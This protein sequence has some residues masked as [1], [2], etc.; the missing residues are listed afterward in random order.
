MTSYANCTDA[1]CL[2]KDYRTKEIFVIAGKG[3]FAELD[4]KKDVES[5][6]WVDLT[7][8]K[9]ESK[10]VE[11]LAQLR[12]CVPTFETRAEAAKGL[13]LGDVV[14]DLEKLLAAGKVSDDDLKMLL[15]DRAFDTLSLACKSRGEIARLRTFL[16]NQKTEVVS[17]QL[18]DV[19]GAAA[20]ISQ[21]GND[22]LTAKGNIVPGLG[23]AGDLA[24]GVKVQM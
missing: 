20:I 22:E 6:E 16:S 17:I 14:V 13:D 12:V 5:P 4:Q 3:C 1:L 7:S 11:R 21:L 15:T 10:L 2:F 24:Y 8:F 19:S 23:D 18:Q 9:S